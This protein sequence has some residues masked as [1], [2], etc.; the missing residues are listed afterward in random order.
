MVGLPE[1]RRGSLT[2]VTR[3][4]T[5]DPTGM[6]VFPL[7]TTA[8][9]IF[10]WKGSPTR[11]LNVASVVSSRT[12]RAVP[13]GTGA[14]VW[15]ATLA[16]ISSRPGNRILFFMVPPEILGP[17]LSDNSRSAIKSRQYAAG[18]GNQ[19]RQGRSAVAR[20][21]VPDP[22]NS[23]EVCRMSHAV[24][25]RSDI[26][27]SF[28][29]SLRV[30]FIRMPRPKTASEFQAYSLTQNADFCGR[31]TELIPSKGWTYLCRPL[32]AFMHAK[33]LIPGEIPRWKRKYS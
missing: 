31:N 21:P 27:M 23:G 30:I 11:L 3:P 25:H 18:Q 15:A 20:W 4:S 29:K 26:I 12:I 10:P 7:I 9:V 28:A 16:A 17:S 8:W 14:L 19:R 2:L 33:F 24:H 13:A 1:M 22:E 32:Q 6:T 5:V